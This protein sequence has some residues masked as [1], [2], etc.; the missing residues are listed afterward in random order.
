[1]K[2]RV[3]AWSAIVFFAAALV[4]P[5]LGLGAGLVAW[6]R[7]NATLVLAE[8]YNV[9]LAL[10]AAIALF[11]ACFGLGILLALRVEK[12]AWIEILL[13]FAASMGYSVLNF[14]PL[15]VDD[16][17]VALGGALTSYAMAAR[18]FEGLSRW[19]MAPTVAAALYTLAGEFVP[20]PIDEAAV[21][22][23]AAIASAVIAELS[24]RRAAK[25]AQAPTEQ[26]D[27]STS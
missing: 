19:T 21:G 1:M 9:R 17:V 6:D 7:D 22:L 26:R 27:T 8:Q 3:F 13:P 11:V 24:S 2:D 14:I 23:V 16:A 10:A 18:R 25:E 4:L 5:A 15:P 12:P 20:G